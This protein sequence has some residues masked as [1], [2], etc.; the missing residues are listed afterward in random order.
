MV[1][2]GKWGLLS[3][4]LRVVIMTSVLNMLVMER[5]SA[6]DAWVRANQTALPVST[7]PLSSTI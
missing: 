5:G 2:R 3:V 4:S 7:T 1:G 6:Q